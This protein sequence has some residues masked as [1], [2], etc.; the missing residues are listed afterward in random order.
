MAPTG[1]VFSPGAVSVFFCFR[2]GKKNFQKIHIRECQRIQ[3]LEIMSQSVQDG[4]CFISLFVVYHVL[5]SLER[6]ALCLVSSAAHRPTKPPGQREGGK[7]GPSL[8]VMEHVQLG[9]VS[10]MEE[11]RSLC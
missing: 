1:P 9:E 2:A 5:C 4:I 8:Q 11:E 3:I 7:V 10:G 6:L